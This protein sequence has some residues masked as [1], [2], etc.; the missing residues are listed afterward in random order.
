MLDAVGKDVVGLRDNRYDQIIHM[1]T[2]ASGAE[3]FYQLANNTVRSESLEM[4]RDLD[5]KAAQV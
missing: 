5:G 2:A 4:A 1:V 3:N